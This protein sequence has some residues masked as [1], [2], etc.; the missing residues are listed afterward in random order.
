MNVIRKH[1]GLRWKRSYYSFH[2]VKLGDLCVFLT[3]IAAAFFLAWHDAQ[4]DRQIA[5]EEGEKAVSNFANFL[6]GGILMDQE[7]TFA[8]KCSQLLEVEK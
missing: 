1:F 7:E 4:V 3:C 8:V 5:I 2:D 6:N